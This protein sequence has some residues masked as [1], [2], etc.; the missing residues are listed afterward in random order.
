MPPYS[1]CHQTAV[2][3][4]VHFHTGGSVKC[5]LRPGQAAQQE[6]T[7]DG[8]QGRESQGGARCH[9]AGPEDMKQ[10]SG[11]ACA[12]NRDKGQQDQQ[13]KDLHQTLSHSHSSQH[14]TPPPCHSPQS[15]SPHS[16]QSRSPHSPQ[17]R[18]T[19][20][21]SP[22]PTSQPIHSP[23][24]LSTFHPP[25]PAQIHGTHP[26]NHNQPP[27]S[28]NQHQSNPL[29]HHPQPK[30]TIHPPVHHL[31]HPNRL[32]HHKP[33]PLNHPNI[34]E[35][36]NQRQSP[37]NTSSHNLSQHRQQHPSGSQSQPPHQL[38]QLPSTSR[39]HTGEGLKPYI[40]PDKDIEVRTHLYSDTFKLK[41]GF[42]HHY[43]E[44]M[45]CIIIKPCGNVLWFYLCQLVKH[46][47]S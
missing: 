26:N 39:G 17:A 1:V 25:Q 34:R 42:V 38:A 30:Y 45:A 22:H 5:Q 12:S 31:H 19:H 23:S 29:N 35:P 4:R 27:T 47:I 6:M 33:R 20:G 2:L 13:H 7:T 16:P 37:Q 8:S 46:G 40:L 10:P 18:P 28:Q 21:P 14:H 15:R 32:L 43:I 9:A 11:A 41:R 36:V 24:S 3:P 44:Y